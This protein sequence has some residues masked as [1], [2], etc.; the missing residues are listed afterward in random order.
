MGK[1][2]RFIASPDEPSEVLQ[3]FL[4]LPNPPHQIQ[5]DGCFWLHFEQLGPL[6]NADAEGFID[7]KMS[8]VAT[9][10]LPYKRR[11][12]LWTV[13]EVHFLATPLRKRFPALHKISSEFEKWLISFECVFSMN[14]GYNPEWNYYLEGSVRNF[15]PPVFAFPS[16]LAALRAGRYFVSD[17][18][19]EALLDR[20]C[21]SLRHRGIECGA[22]A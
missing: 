5:A 21:M 20:L 15:D 7:P 2:Y 9:L 16:G 1:T 18:D 3:W 11:G 19:T 4:K 17:D 6:V 13:G 8:P 22:E 14:P 12:I 10:F